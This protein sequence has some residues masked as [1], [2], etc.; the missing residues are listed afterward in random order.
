[1]MI[2]RYAIIIHSL[3]LIVALIFAIIAEPDTNTYLTDPV[4]E[5]EMDDIKR[6]I[7]KNEEK[8]IVIENFS[9]D[10][11]NKLFIVE[12]K[13][14]ES[15][16]LDHEDG[17][18][19][20]SSNQVESSVENNE[21]VNENGTNNIELESGANLSTEG[22]VQE[23]KFRG[24]RSIETLFKNLSPLKAKRIFY[25]ITSGC[26]YTTINQNIQLGVTIE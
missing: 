20:T 11:E 21:Q 17:E 7:F 2:K 25:D 22:S 16:N 8:E 6:I 18:N 13:I 15:E 24:G 5:L 3:L 23:H 26:K 4:L 1:M 19:E 9:Q 12:A 14:K 10:E